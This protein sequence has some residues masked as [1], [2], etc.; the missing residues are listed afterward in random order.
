LR[1]TEGSV[2]IIA[3][4][5]P[6]L[7]PLVEKVRNCAWSTNG[8]IQGTYPKPNSA[9]GNNK[10]YA[11]IELSSDE[12]RIVRARRKFEMDSVLETRNSDENFGALPSKGGRQDR[13]L[14][15]DEIELA[16]TVS[17]A[18]RHGSSISSEAIKKIHRTDEV[19]IVYARDD[20]SSSKPH[21]H[22]EN[23]S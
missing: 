20:G 22:Q 13:I 16:N 15:E 21:R 19:R 23:W 14:V 3:A 2:I 1:S 7:H 10:G 4:C 6:L 8:G 18:H 11:D 12:S 5:I 9:I 17:G